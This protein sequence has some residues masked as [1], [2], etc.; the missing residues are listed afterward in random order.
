MQNLI[1]LFFGIWCLSVSCGAHSELFLSD[2]ISEGRT[3]EKSFSILEKTFFSQKTRADITLPE[4][5]WTVRR[6]GSINSSHQTPVV[7]LNVWLD[8]VANKHIQEVLTV[9]IYPSGASKWS[10]A[11]TPGIT[12][13]MM[14][15]GV[16]SDCHQLEVTSFMSNLNS[17]IQTDIRKKW[18]TQGLIW[19]NTA[20]SFTSKHIRAGAGP[21]I[22][23]YSLALNNY[24][25]PSNH[26]LHSSKINGAIDS[27]EKKH[28]IDW[29]NLFFKE[30]ISSIYEGEKLRKTHSQEIAS[31]SKTQKYKDYFVGLNPAGTNVTQSKPSGEIKELESIKLAELTKTPLQHSEKRA[32]LVI[33][34]ANYKIRPL[35]NPANDAEDV[36]SSLKNNGFEVIAVKDADLRGMRSA[37]RAF[38][39]LLVKSDVGLVYYS[40]H[41]VEVKGRNYFIPVDADIQREDEISDQALDVNLIM[42]KIDTAQR[43][44]NILIVD[45][46]RDDPFG[47]SYRSTTRG[48]ASM[49]SPPGT[50]IAFSTSPGK[51]ASDGDPKE[52]NSPYTKHLLEEMKK[53]NLPIEQVFKEV[54]RKV[55]IETKNTQTPWE[56]TSLSRDF[57]FSSTLR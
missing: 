50:I 42:E 34:N 17:Q 3:I 49:D 20:L 46:C 22:I 25:N 15:G 1:K 40:G 21:V 19:T 16:N 38:G 29:A 48:L 47:R 51:V 26:G 41:G 55:Q 45:A 2:N 10:D 44:V 30:N 8:K 7:G 24:S 6:V 4:G 37:V 39:D 11:C 28:I 5:K 56:N 54:R 52:R 31:L 36:T 12:G 13:N 33:G 57:Y 14:L 18:D 27:D 53:P 43:K 35:K 9:S 23:Y 32:A